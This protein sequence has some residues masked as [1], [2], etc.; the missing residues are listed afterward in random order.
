[1]KTTNLFILLL[2]MIMNI[3]CIRNVKKNSLE[4]SHLEEYKNMADSAFEQNDFQKAEYYLNKV[5]EYDST[6]GLYYYNR[7]YCRGRKFDRKGAIYDYTKAIKLNFSVG[8]CY[9]NISVVYLSNNDYSRGKYY[10]HLADSILPGDEVIKKMKEA[11][12]NEE[13]K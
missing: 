8:N 3:C 7:G 1:M 13:L 4:I 11:L 5:I 6:D 2:L 12:R 9:L 10:L